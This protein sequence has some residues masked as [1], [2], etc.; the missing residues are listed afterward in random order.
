[1]SP[2]N[3]EQAIKGGQPLISQV[4]VVG[5]RRPYNVALIILDRDGVAGF[6]RDHELAETALEKLTGHPD[7]LGAVAAAV[8]AGNQRLS[9]PEQ[10]RR[11]QVLD[12]DWPLGGEQLTPTAKVRRGE[13]ARQ[14][15]A[16]IDGLYG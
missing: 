14:Y 15:Q 10:I 4:L 11:Y 3:I 13:V 5:D 6:A 8:G 9:R 2:A 12:H 1:M 7:V 16:V